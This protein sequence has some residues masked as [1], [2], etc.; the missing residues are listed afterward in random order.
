MRKQ[1]KTLALRSNGLDKACRPRARTRIW[2]WQSRFLQALRKTPSVSV[3]CKAAGISRDTAYT[4]RLKDEAFASA[5][6]SALGASVD[7]LETKAFE[8]AM[9]GDS[10][11]ITFMLRCH[12]PEN[13]TRKSAWTSACLAGLYSFQAR[14]LAKNDTLR[15]R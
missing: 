3:A 4:H 14:L 9:A 8:L 5:W 15:L 10:T 12:K 6:L 1:K 13:T 2:Q 11:L 7:E